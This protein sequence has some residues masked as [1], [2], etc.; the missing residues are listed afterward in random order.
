MTPP[1]AVGRGLAPHGA[2]RPKVALVFP[3]FRYPSGDYPLGIATLAAYLRTHLPVDVVVCD[4]TFDPRMERVTEFLDAEAPDYVGI[5]MSTLMLGEGLEVARIA[6]ARGVPVFVGGPHPT[7]DPEALLAEESIDAVVIG[8][9]EE[10]TRALLED[11]MAQRVAPVEGC[12][13]KAPDGTVLRGGKRA[14][15]R[16]LDALPQPAWDLLDMDAYLAAWGQ[17]DSWRPGLR[18]VNVMASRGCP[19][20]CSF[21]QPV[22][23]AMFGKKLRAR[24]PENVVAEIVALHARYGIEGF[25][26]TDDTFT[27]NRTWV[28]R[29]CAL[30]RATGLEL[31]W[32]CTTR[33]NL[34]APELMRTMAEAGLRKVGIGME[35]ATERIREGLYQK[36]VTQEAITHTVEVARDHGVHTLLFLMLGA[37]GETRREMLA[38]IEM[39]TA[40]PASEASFSLFVPIPGT[41]LWTRMREEG[42]DMSTD[43][44]DYDYYAR[45]PFQGEISRRELRMLQRWAYLRF[46]SHPARWRSVGR[47]ASTPAGLKSLG[48]KLLRIVPHGMAPRDPGA[49]TRTAAAARIVRASGASAERA[50]R[51]RPPDVAVRG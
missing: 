49:D 43:Y 26:F 21:C 47:S 6:H 46:Y 13:R 36:G 32:G 12:W 5:G 34:I 37:P 15:I 17:L 48:R 11:W 29:F 25:W 10:T 22:L 8:E 50:D 38:T 9:G 35:S 3:R 51:N 28:T 14:G 27:T 20:A 41:A 18:G 45:Q 33:A 42:W 24:S 23:D 40:L 30:L 16:D 2:R 39:A 7:T 19:Y 31:H 1:D 44:T 4:T